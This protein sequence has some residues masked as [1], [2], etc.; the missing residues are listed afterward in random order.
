M[1]SIFKLYQKNIKVSGLDM[2]ILGKL[3]SFQLNSINRL[4]L[5]NVYARS[6]QANKSHKVNRDI[7]R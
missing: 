1:P 3:T 7:K 6:S 5:V 4:Q 2:K